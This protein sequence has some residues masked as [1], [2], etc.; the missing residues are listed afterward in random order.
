MLITDTKIIESHAPDMPTKEYNLD[1]PEHAQLHHFRIFPAMSDRKAWTEAAENPYNRQLLED[2][3]VKAQQALET[4]I[5]ELT[6]TRYMDFAR[7][8]NRIAFERPYFNRRITLEA[9]VLAEAY[10][11]K[12]RF[13]D[14]IVDYLWA[15]LSE[16]TWCL[17]A[18]TESGSDPFA[19]PEY[20]KVDLFS[21]DTAIYLS[22]TMMLMEDELAAISPNLV[23]RVRVE[24]M[25]RSIESVEATLENRH[26]CRGYA[27]WT[28]WICSNL[29][30]TANWVLK[31]DSARFT[32]FASRLDGCMLRFR[33]LYP[34]DGCCTEGPGYWNLSPVR[35]FMYIDG[36]A[37]ASDDF[38]APRLQDLKFQ[39]MCGFI[40]DAW[41]TRH[42]F[43]SFS[44]YTA[45][46]NVYFGTIRAMGLRAE[47]PRVTEFAEIFEAQNADAYSMSH[48][49]IT[50]TLYA[51]FTPRSK[52]LPTRSDYLAVYPNSQTLYSTWRDEFVAMKGGHNSEPHNHND[53]GQFI[54]G[55]GG[56]MVVLDLGSEVYSRKTF[57]SERYDLLCQSGR[58]HNPLVF[59]GIPQHAGPAYKARDFRVEGKSGDFTCTV[60]L[61]EC[62]PQAA[63][64][65]EYIRMVTYCEGRLIVED[66]WK[67][68]RAVLPT[69]TL[70]LQKPYPQLQVEGGEVMEETMP[71]TDINLCNSWGNAIEKVTITGPRA[72]AGSLTLRF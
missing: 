18:H 26:W 4:P 19:D 30:W 25:R 53:I 2:M 63:G 1:A 58:G 13:T 69:M 56:G 21:A 60:N 61:T 24:L 45:R 12:R 47:V 15:I 65:T 41:Y 5:A 39:R 22:Q 20:E 67:A 16:A 3:K 72:P 36:L 35:Y 66:A 17:P 7:N 29:F 54:Y 34:D 50:M 57:S 11:Y 51:I 48:T 44:D 28:P 38:T 64:I 27:N 52:T 37:K 32:R 9:L 6:A 62:Y 23:R 55:K 14:R 42:I 71:L 59:D 10:E 40:A 8:G 68:E 49:G 70:F 31:D 46:S 43:A 33:R